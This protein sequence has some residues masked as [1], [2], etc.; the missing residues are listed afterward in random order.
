MSLPSFTIPVYIVNYNN[1]ERKQAVTRAFKRFNITPKFS[2]GISPIDELWEYIPYIN[3][4]VRPTWCTMLDHLDNIR[5]F[6]NETNEYFG[7]FCEDDIMLSY[8]FTDRAT[9]IAKIAFEN[10]YDLVLLSSLIDYP[11]DS[12][13]TLHTKIMNTPF[14]DLYTYHSELWGAH[15]YMLSRPQA[16]YI[17]EKYNLQWAQRHYNDSPFCVDWTITKDGKRCMVYPPL[18]IEEGT[19]NTTDQGQIQFHQSCRQ[20]LQT[21]DN[22]Y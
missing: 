5:R 4:N 13:P 7:I 21:L 8:N 22:Y 11:P 3:K 6:V 2:I 15:M 20:H 12:N 10:D 18:A 14:G 9:K 1:D 19:V 16:K 17:I